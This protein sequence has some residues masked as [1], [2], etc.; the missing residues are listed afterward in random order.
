MFELGER[1][2]NVVDES[3]L[4]AIFYPMVSASE[5]ELKDEIERHSALISEKYGESGL[6]A[7]T[8]AT[9]IEAP[10]V[11]RGYYAQ[12]ADELERRLE[13]EQRQKIMLRKQ[14]ELTREERL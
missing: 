2:V 7:F 3:K 6:R 11:L 14:T 9:G 13:H 8:E 5:E 4:Q 1:N 12:K 10:M